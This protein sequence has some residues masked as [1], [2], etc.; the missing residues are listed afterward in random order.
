MVVE[1]IAVCV[2]EANGKE[3]YRPIY[4]DS[5]RIYATYAFGDL[6]ATAT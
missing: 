6:V 4:E 3:L 5:K 1:E 2:F